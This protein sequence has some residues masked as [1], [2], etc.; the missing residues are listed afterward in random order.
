[1]QYKLS[2]LLLNKNAN[3][4]DELQNYEYLI[5]RIGLV[6]RKELNNYIKNNIIKNNTHV[7]KLKKDSG[8]KCTLK[9]NN[10]K[11][12]LEQFKTSIFILDKLCSISRHGDKLFGFCFLNSKTL[13]KKIIYNYIT[14][15]NNNNNSKNI[16]ELILNLYKLINILALEN[17]NNI[18]NKFVFLNKCRVIIERIL[19]ETKINEEEITLLCDKS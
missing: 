13:L 19:P 1:M 17:S 5:I 2:N 14:Y 7:F 16:K 3:N 18:E 10:L 11:T 9:F 12:F 4:S 8:I 6:L 15:E